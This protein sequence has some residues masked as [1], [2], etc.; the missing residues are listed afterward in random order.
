MEA[1]GGEAAAALREA[2]AK[3]GSP[4]VRKLAGEVL[5]RVENAPPKAD[6]LR[7]L[8]AVEV[9]EHLGSADAKAL[10]AKWAAG[11]AGRRLTTESAAALARLKAR[12]P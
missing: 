8:R 5:A 10:L 4:E 12:G 3:S 2:A 1:V 6:D 11:P 9:L 7:A